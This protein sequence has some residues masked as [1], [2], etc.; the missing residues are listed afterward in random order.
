MASSTTPPGC[1]QTLARIPPGSP[2]SF[3]EFAASKGW[4]AEHHDAAVSVYGMIRD[5]GPD[6]VMSLPPTPKEDAATIARASELLRTNPDAYWRD[7]DLQGAQLE[8]LER[9]EAAP[10]AEPDRA[11]VADQIERQI[12]QRDVNKFAEMLRTLALWIRLR[13]ERSS[14]WFICH[15]RDRLINIFI[16]H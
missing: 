1:T 2:E 9:R 7:H 8:A 13:S 5:Q 6:A 11:A 4:Q 3:S 14:L 12:A 10:P 15:W 16:N